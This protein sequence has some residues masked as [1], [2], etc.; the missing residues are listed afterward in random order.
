M[1]LPTELYEY[2][3]QSA[4]DNMGKMKQLELVNLVITDLFMVDG[5]LT[6][7]VEKKIYALNAVRKLI[8]ADWI[9]DPK[10][11]D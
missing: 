9:K 4:W 11:D 5:A 10:G 7:G 8:I 1:K 3:G 2:V 6:A